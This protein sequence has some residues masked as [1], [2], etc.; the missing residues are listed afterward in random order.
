MGQADYMNF[1]DVAIAFSQEEWEIL[2]EAQRRLYCDVM[3][4]VFALVS[5]IGSSV[6]PA[7]SH[8]V[9]PDQERLAPLQQH[10]P[11][12]SPVSGTCPEGDGE[13]LILLLIQASGVPLEVSS[14]GWIKHR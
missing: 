8:P 9:N 2:D 14:Q 12:G 7:G 6:P 1:E 11:A 4:E 5:F 10:S 13:S 3:L